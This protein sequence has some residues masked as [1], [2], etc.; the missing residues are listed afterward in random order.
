MRKSAGLC[1]RSACGY[2]PPG[3]SRVAAGFGVGIQHFWRWERRREK[4]AEGENSGPEDRL[5]LDGV[6]LKNEIGFHLPEVTR[7]L[8][9]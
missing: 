6:T 7:I 9:G 3:R 2:P 4:P 1:G 8:L 5:R